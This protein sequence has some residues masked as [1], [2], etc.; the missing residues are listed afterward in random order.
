MNNSRKKIENY[1]EELTNACKQLNWSK[2][3]LIRFVYIMLGRELSKS[4]DFFYSKEGKYGDNELSI[5]QM[6]EIHEKD[7][8]YEVTCQVTAKMLSKIYNELGIM[9]E[10]RNTVNPQYY[11][12]DGKK[13]PIYHTYLIVE[14]DDQKKY[15]LSLNNDLVNIKVGARTECFGA[16]IPYH[17][18]GTQSYVGEEIKHSF[19]DEKKLEKIDSEIGY[20]IPIQDGKQG[21]VYVYT[22]DFAKQDVYGKSRGKIGNSEDYLASKIDDLDPVFLPMLKDFQRKTGKNNLSAL[23]EAEFNDLKWSVLYAVYNLISSK[24]GVDTKNPDNLFDNMFEDIYTAE[25]G[26]NSVE[27]IKK[28][29]NVITQNPNSRVD[30]TPYK[31]LK[32]AK[33]FILAMT[34]L[35]EFSLDKNADTS[36]LRK[37][38][39]FFD[40]AKIELAKYFIP[41]DVLRKYIEDKNPSSEFI[42][43][44][45]KTMFE[46]DFECDTSRL[47]GY[48]PDILNK[49]MDLVEQTVFF[50]KYLLKI[51]RGEFPTESDF[52][53]RIIFSSMTQKGDKNNHA[54]LIH[55]KANG[56]RDLAYTVLYDPQINDLRTVNYLYVKMNYNIYSKTM[57]N[58]FESGDEGKDK[59]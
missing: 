6:K 55:I 33:H 31:I 44:K 4:T 10:L 52:Y 15:F 24:L 18:N 19:F 34:R 13:Y 37:D 16:D 59:Q 46:Q 56:E 50:K 41:E 11:E 14:G 20:S 38:R 48:M 32:N 27:M 58:H 2:D 43:E 29:E 28:I 42:Y 3:K 36:E 21:I 23:S 57:K 7:F 47:T 25:E 22:P 17:F 51:F 1:I 49:N 9:T 26:F 54:F 30:V 45:L 40:E 5:E 8:A 12:K 53:N 35:R 39:K